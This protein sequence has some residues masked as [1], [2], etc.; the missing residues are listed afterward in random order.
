[1]FC[2]ARSMNMSP[3]PSQFN[4]IPSDLHYVLPGPLLLPLD[5]WPHPTAHSLRTSSWVLLSKYPNTKVT[6]PTVALPHLLPQHPTAMYPLPHLTHS[7]EPNSPAQQKKCLKAPPPCLL[8]QVLLAHTP[9]RR[10]ACSKIKA[11]IPGSDCMFRG[12]CSRPGLSLMHS[13]TFGL[14]I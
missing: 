4:Y 13:L 5:P 7:E 8:L 1:M 10:A 9:R 11:N 2:Q 12:T 14:E 6:C 3:W